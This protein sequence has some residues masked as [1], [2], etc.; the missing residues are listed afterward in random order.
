MANRGGFSWKRLLGVTK[1]KQK[2]SR[3]IGIPL[4]KSGRQR[5]LGKQ[6]GGCVVFFLLSF[7]VFFILLGFT[8]YLFAQ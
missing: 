5:K 2:L 3:K 4:T 7:I 8:V 6:L 1:A